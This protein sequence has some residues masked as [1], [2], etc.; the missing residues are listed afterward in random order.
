MTEILDAAIM[1]NKNGKTVINGPK[2]VDDIMEKIIIELER[3]EDNSD[4]IFMRRV[5]GLL[6]NQH[7]I[8]KLE[9]NAH[10]EAHNSSPIYYEVEDNIYEE[11]IKQKKYHLLGL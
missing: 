1:T 9:I 8:L 2:E 10:R 7:N 6:Q 3:K 11:I 4:V 5:I